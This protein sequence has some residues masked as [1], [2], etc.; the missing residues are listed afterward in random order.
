MARYFRR[1]RRGVRTVNY[2]NYRNHYKGRMTRYY[3]RS[4]LQ[5]SMPFLAGLGIGLT[6]LDNNIP[7]E[8]KLVAACLPFRG[9]GIG[10]IKAAAQGMILGDIVQ[11]RMG[12]NLF[13]GIKGSSGTI[14][15]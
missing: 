11:K 12:V 10:T 6:D 2:N 1:G 5:V 3:K 15:V 8:I 7:P 13:G 9:K 4:G 14:Q